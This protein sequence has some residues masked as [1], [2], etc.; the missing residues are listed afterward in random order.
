[1][2][3]GRSLAQLDIEA[4][5]LIRKEAGCEHVFSVSAY[6]ID[7][8]MFGLRDLVVGQADKTAAE[9]GRLNVERDLQQRYTLIRRD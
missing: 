8:T 2:K 1:M 3:I 5:E 7:D 4:L 9:Q 6:R